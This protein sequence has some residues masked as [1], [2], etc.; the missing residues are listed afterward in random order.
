MLMKRRGEEARYARGIELALEA[1]EALGAPEVLV[2][3]R[4]ATESSESPLVAGGVLLALADVE[5]DRARAIA[6]AQAR[7]LRE[8]ARRGDLVPAAGGA[9][10][11]TG[12]AACSLAALARWDGAADAGPALLELAA[13]GDRCPPW[14]GAPVSAAPGEWDVAAAVDVLL[15]GELLGRPLPALAA[16]VEAAVLQGGLAC[17]SGGRLTPRPFVFALALARWLRLAKGHEALRRRVFADCLGRV[18]HGHSE[19]VECAMALTTLLTVGPPPGEGWPEVLDELAARCAHQQTELG[20]WPASPLFTSGGDRLIGSLHLGTAVCIEALSRFLRMRSEAEDDPAPAHPA[21]RRGRDARG[22]PSLRT[23]AD[24]FG[25]IEA[26]LPSELVSPEAFGHLRE[27]GGWV[28]AALACGFGLE[29]RLADPSPRADV[30]FLAK[31]DAGERE[32]LAGKDPHVQLSPELRSHPVWQSIQAFARQWADP[33]S[34]LFQDIGSF[35]FEFDLQAPPA[36]PPAPVIFVTPE[37]IPPDNEGGPSRWERYL[38]I[39]VNALESLSTGPVDPG[40]ARQLGTC[41]RAMPSPHAHVEGVGL[42]LARQLN[43][44]RLSLRHFSAGEVL[45]YLAAV[46]WTGSHA[47]AAELMGWLGGL[48]DRFLINVD[49]AEGEVLP[50]LGVECSYF[51]RRQPRVEPRWQRFMDE[52]VAR[53]LCLP[54]KRDAL[55]AWQGDYTCAERLEDETVESRFD[56][57]VTHVKLSLKPGARLEAKGYLG[58]W[59][60]F[61]VRRPRSP[62]RA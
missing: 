11:G 47:D 3:T 20:L 10:V 27:V 40:L 38:A 14:L 8:R 30:F 37:M 2:A 15:L 48:V 29:V 5:G 32:I 57:R 26:E 13:A 54:S 45:S 56:R 33:S 50:S 16:S 43:A 55:L 51:G 46:G 31:H 19:P 17:P 44:V 35:W 6:E 9:P 53:G 59:R 7:Y 22:L 52:L 12:E 21:A 25:A 62:T 39:T 34:T 28:P 23:W 1:L 18:G 24:T 41:L 58:S 60:N 36:R 49:V 4:E 42:M 61:E